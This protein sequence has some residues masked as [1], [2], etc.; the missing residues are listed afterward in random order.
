MNLKA[1]KVKLQR[2]YGGCLGARV[3]E[4]RDKLRKDM[5]SRK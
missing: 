2:A 5:E 4:G 1:K 3:D